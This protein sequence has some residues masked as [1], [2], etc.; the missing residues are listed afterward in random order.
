MRLIEHVDSAG[1][2][3]RELHRVGDDGRKHGFEIKRRVH[4]LRDVAERFQLLNRA[5]ELLRSRLKLIKQPNILDRDHGLVGES[6]NQ[7][8][9]PVSKGLHPLASE[10]DRTD[11][12]PLAQ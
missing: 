9:L 5:P 6:P 1:I 11:H 8:D 3:T 7:L 10:I 12:D 4:R 2:G